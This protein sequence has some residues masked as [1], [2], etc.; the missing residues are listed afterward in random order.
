MAVME[1]SL[2]DPDWSAFVLASTGATA[3][4]HPSWAKLLSR[5]YKYRGL[6][7]ADADTNGR[8]IAGL[9]LLDVKVPFRGRKWVSLPFTDHCP[10]LVDPGED[11]A[12]LTTMLMAKVKSEGLRRVEVRAELGNDAVA[13]TAGVI[14]RLRLDPDP[15]AVFARFKRSQVQRNVRRAEKQGIVVERSQERAHLIDIFYP[16]HVR[17]RRRQG[18]PVQPRRYFELLWEA[19]IEQGLGYVSVAYAGKKP[20]ASAVFLTWK[21]TVIYKYGASD[22]AAWPLRPNHLLFW[23]AIEASCRNG[24]HTFDFGRTESSNDG[25]RSF[26]GGWDAEEMPL[27]YSIIGGTDRSRSSAHP[28]ATLV[29]PAL[30]H[31]PLWACRAVGALLYRYAA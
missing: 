29:Q 13:T 12:Q 25:L 21:G 14:H 16:L 22:E 26:K 15:A 3:F 28:V 30:R 5:C 4:H 24:D 6:A 27:H 1:L 31:A 10:P 17:T 20:V 23:D 11:V 18:V 9:P 7:L 2:H 8:I 19:M